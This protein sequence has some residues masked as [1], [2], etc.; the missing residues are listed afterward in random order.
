MTAHIS[1]DGRK[2]EESVAEHTKKTAA[3]CNEKGKRCGLAQV[4]TLCGIYHDMGKCKKKF[5]DYINADAATKQKLRGTIAHA[6][7]GAKYFYDRYH[8]NANDTKIMTELISYAI[9][10]HHG[11]FDCV[12]IEHV[13]IFTKKV[14]KVEDYNEACM[15]AKT[16]YLDEFGADAVFA[17]ASEEFNVVWNKM[18]EL[19]EKLKSTIVN[20]DYGDVKEQLSCYRDFLL[21]CLQRLILSILIDSDWEATS[22]FMDNV[23]TLS[24]KVDINSAEVFRKAGENFEKY[25]QKKQQ[26]FQSAKSTE[27]EN[28]IF[29]A[30]NA[31]QKACRDFAAHPAGIYCLSIPT[32]GGKTLSSL[33]YALEYC[34]HHIRT[35][36]IIYVSPYIS[37]TEQN[38]KVFREAV[39]CDDWILEHH[40]SVVRNLESEDE[41]AGG[42]SRYEMNWEEPFI[43]TTFVQFM[44]TLFSD[45]SES[46][47]R[48]HRLVNAVVII[49]EVQSMPPKCIHTFNYM[50]NFLKVVCNTDIILCTATQPALEQT[51]CPVCYSTPKDMISNVNNWFYKFDRVKIILPDVSKYYDFESLG[52]ELVKQSEKFQSILVVLNTK[53]AVRRLYDILKSRNI[54]AVYMTTNLCAQHRADKIEAIQKTLRERQDKI[55]VISTNLIEAGVDISFECVY[56]SMAGLDSL[57]QSA[58]R[59]NRN[60]ELEYG[61]VYLIQLEGENTGS[62]DDLLE[63]KNVAEYIIYQYDKSDKMD[64]LLMPRWMEKY[65]INLYS[66]TVDKMNF[67]LLKPDYNI[68][69]LLSKGFRIQKGKNIMCQA[70]KTAGQ[71]YRVIDDYSFGVIVPYMEGENLIDS[72]QNASELSDIKAFIRKAQRYTVNVRENQLKKFEGLI[73]PVSDH[74]PNLYMVA[75]SGAYNHEYGI[76]QEWETLI[77]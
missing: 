51:E 31:L 58:G 69:E 22:D 37:V 62:M 67:P 27:K 77:F 33:A 2:R 19:Y 25:M 8:D 70:F 17:G 55:V 57:T 76:S 3:L 49:D 42:V 39:G 38:A 24:K 44:N 74:I 21:S 28:G 6:S 23:D 63:N 53:S 52:D 64:S 10:A 47:R 13:D 41:R 61:V 34:R 1:D 5:E 60:G 43:C 29:E 73:Q 12:D 48:M 54:N 9:A 15:N 35:E 18:K 46:I 40:S 56:R 30:R 50:I 26:L 59:C 45:K 16:D 36:R 66:K 68:M 20:K 65:Y 71:A 7:T 14:S 75:A 72:I 4:M 32:G 11:I